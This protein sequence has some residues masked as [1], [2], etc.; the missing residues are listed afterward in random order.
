M[1]AHFPSGSEITETPYD[2]TKSITLQELQSTNIDWIT[3][4]LIKTVFKLF[5]SK[6]S[7]GTDGIK[8]I[9]YKHLP[10][11]IIQHL[12]IIYKAVIMLKYTPKIWKEAKLIFIPKPGKSS[13]KIA[14]SWRPI[15]LTNYLIKALE[16]LCV[17]E[18]DKA[19]QSNP[20]HTR[21][22]GFRADR[23]TVTLSLKSLTS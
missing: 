2:F 1:Q 14:K 22:H 23:N 8:P 20:V 19:L 10:T 3:P 11:N 17:W 21:R 12:Q 6:K 16:K 15:S 5:K 13:Y 4:E 9:A 7:P 18:S